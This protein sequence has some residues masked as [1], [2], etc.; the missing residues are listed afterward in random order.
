MLVLSLPVRRKDLRSH[1]AWLLFFSAYSIFPYLEVQAALCLLSDFGCL[2]FAVWFSLFAF[3]CLLFTICISL[4]RLWVPYSFCILLLSIFF[5]LYL[6]LFTSH[7]FRNFYSLGHG[8]MA[9]TAVFGCVCQNWTAPC[10]E[11]RGIWKIASV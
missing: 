11:S 2:L 6:I 10:P 9:A 5:S 7:S 8:R 1:S 4:S 3:R